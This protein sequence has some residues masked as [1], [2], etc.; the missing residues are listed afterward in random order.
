MINVYN[1]YVSKNYYLKTMCAVNM[2]MVTWDE[3][4]QTFK[5][6]GCTL[7]CNQNDFTKL[8]MKQKYKYIASCGHEHEVWLH[9]FKNRG[10]GVICPSCVVRESIHLHQHKMK[11]NKLS[12]LDMERR[13]I[14]NLAILI[15]GI[16]EIKI[17]REGCLADIA[18]KPKTDQMV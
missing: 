8:Y 4:T 1:A 6:Y 17:T 18:I 5:N 2:D 16:F 9:V 11:D 10:T 12:Y 13:S 7:L 14:E 15:S 3:V